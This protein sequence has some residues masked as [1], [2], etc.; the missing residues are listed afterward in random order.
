MDEKCRNDHPRVRPDGTSNVY[1]YPP[2]AGRKPRITCRTCR[3][4]E[5]VERLSQE[6]RVAKLAEREVA[7][8]VP[9]RLNAY[10]E[11]RFWGICRGISLEKYPLR[12]AWLMAQLSPELVQ[13]IRE[14]ADLL[15][16]GVGVFDIHDGNLDKIRA[17]ID[18]TSAPE[19]KEEDHDA[20]A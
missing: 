18:G 9:K 6:E 5:S 10:G 3:D 7:K 15:E 11:L 20:Q 2:R 13:D 12:L 8:V 17:R 19:K 4:G 16:R 14:A 1:I